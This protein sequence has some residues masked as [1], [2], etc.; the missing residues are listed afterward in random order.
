MNCEVKK[1]NGD[2]FTCKTSK[3]CV[4]MKWRCDNETDCVD[5]SDEHSCR[6]S[7]LYLKGKVF[8]GKG[9]IVR[10]RVRAFGGA[11]YRQPT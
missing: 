1:C 7:F 6:K 3:K 10:V 9:F 2:E 4:P 8:C 5:G 11:V